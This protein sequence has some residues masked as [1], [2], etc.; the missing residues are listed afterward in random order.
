MNTVNR[1][2]DAQ[3]P[4]LGATPN[5]IQSGDVIEEELDMT[6][7]T[8]DLDPL[9]EQEAEPFI[10]GQDAPPPPPPKAKTAQQKAMAV[11]FYWCCSLALVF[12]NKYVMVGDINNLDAP[13]FM[14]WT[15]FLITVICCALLGQ[16]GKFFKPFSFF[17]TFE[18][19][20]AIARKV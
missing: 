16:I 1:R 11:V 12:L 20:L 5:T 10:K 19:N 13:L 3:A 9:H 17:P 4:V 15:Q 8:V 18:Y 7:V 2:K 6:Q 14:S